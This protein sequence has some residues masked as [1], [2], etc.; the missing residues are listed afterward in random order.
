MACGGEPGSLAQLPFLLL[1]LTAGGP[2]VKEER[3]VLL[4]LFL[5]PSLGLSFVVQHQ[6]WVVMATAVSHHHCADGAGV[7]VLDLEEAL[8]YVDV[9]RFNI[10]W[11]KSKRM[12]RSDDWEEEFY[13]YSRM[14]TYFFI[15][16]PVSFLVKPKQQK[17][18]TKDHIFYNL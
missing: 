18:F 9:F 11:E 4:L 10:L 2:Q 16:K 15:F 6:V 17:C 3:L 1:F 13:F 7:D 8:D 12:R 14:K 5:P